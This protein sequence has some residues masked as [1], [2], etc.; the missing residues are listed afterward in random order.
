MTEDAG[1]VDLTVGATLGGKSKAR[2][3]NL[4]GYVLT[5]DAKGGERRQNIEIELLDVPFP[6][7]FVEGVRK[8]SPELKS[9]YSP[10]KNLLLHKR[11]ITPAEAACY[12]GHRLIWEK[13]TKQ[14]EE[15]GI[16]F[17]DDALINDKQR[18][19]VTIDD[20]S[21]GNFDI[22]RLFDLWPKKVALRSSFRNTSLIVHKLIAS[23][24]CCYV[25][26][27]EAAARMLARKTIFR[28]IDEDIA[29]PWEFGIRVWSADPNPVTE[30]AFASN[31]EAD[32]RSVPHSRLRSFYGVLLQGKKQVRMNRYLASLR[33][34][35]GAVQPR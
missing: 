12:A 18:F 31:I 13:I 33:K 9:L 1:V 3:A 29:H 14:V 10:L 26:S 25:V 19:V 2:V 15:Y 21:H 34:A 22:V 24:A 4:R 7:E 17:E 8:N 32:R 6:W 30:A 23:S 35:S 11:S 27:R 16:V 5:I 28:P 20:I